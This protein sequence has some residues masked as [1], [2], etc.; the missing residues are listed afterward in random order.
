MQIKDRTMIILT[1]V[2]IKKDLQT[3]SVRTPL[4]RDPHAGRALVQGVQHRNKRFIVL[5]SHPR[6]CW[7]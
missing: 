1:S 4:S 3:Y 5:V 6:E 2:V 7:V